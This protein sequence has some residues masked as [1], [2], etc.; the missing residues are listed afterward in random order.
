[1]EAFEVMDEAVS[2]SPNAD[3]RACYNGRI[4]FY[5]DKVEK[6]LYLHFETTF[7]DFIMEKA[8]QELSEIDPEMDFFQMNTVLNCRFA[9]LFLLAVHVSHI[10]V[11]VDPGNTFDASCLPL[12]R[13]INI[14]R[15]KLLP[16]ILSKR[17][18]N[19]EVAAI[20]GKEFRLCSPRIVFYFDKPVNA[21][22]TDEDR[23]EIE[24][25]NEIYA[26][27]KHENVLFRNSSLFSIPKKMP[28]VQVNRERNKS[29]DPVQ[30]TINDLADFLTSFSR[31]VREGSEDIDDSM[32][33]CLGFGKSLNLYDKTTLD[34]EF[35]DL[36][37]RD[38]IMKKSLPDLIKKHVKDAL[39]SGCENNPR[40]RAKSS[41]FI[42][43]TANAWLEIF[44]L[45]YEIFE[46]NP[47]PTGLT[48]DEMPTVCI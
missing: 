32:R 9:Q 23:Y 16:K 40:F 8:L 37:K 19:Q 46:I 11:F 47:V 15:E 42:T 6:I 4:I 22:Q 13:S 29:R 26:L 10:I 41:H 48:S 3:P 28:F 43:P 31:E 35:E 24:L 36:K 39:A 27:L 38:S 1:M 20:M 45:F 33:P 18:K 14:A 34:R 25:E 17:L 44:N 21:D 5:V 7:D 30:E 2:L 12:F